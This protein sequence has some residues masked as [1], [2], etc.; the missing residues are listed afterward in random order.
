MD[1]Q[2]KNNNQGKFFVRTLKID[3]ENT[4]NEESRTMRFPIASDEPVS[5]GFVTEILSHEPGAMRLGSRQKSMPLLFNHDWN[6]LCGV[7]EAIDQQEHR[8]YATVRFA[9][10]EEGEKAFNLVRERILTNV[11]CGYQVNRARSDP[12]TRTRTATDW[13]LFEVSLVTVPADPT[14]GVYRSFNQPEFTEEKIMPDQENKVEARKAPEAVQKESK[15]DIAEIQKRAAAEAT[16]RIREIQGMCRDFHISES[17]ADEFINSDRSVDQVRAAVME[18]L[19]SRQA[20]PAALE[21]R[22]FELDMDIGLTE[23]EKSAYSLT[24]ALKAYCTGR[25]NQA[26]FEREVN[27]ALCKR[28]GRESQGFFMP[29]DIPFVGNRAYVA[30]SDVDGGHTIAT[31]LRAGSFIEMIRMKSIILQLGATYLTGLRGKVEIPRQTGSGSAQ[32]IPETG[33]VEPSNAKFDKIA[34]NMKTV[35]AK[36]F[37]SRNLMMQSSLNVESFVRAELVRILAEAID[38]AALY[39]AG[40]NYEPLGIANYDGIHV[41]EGGENGANL[42]FDHLIQMETMVAE[43]NA[44]VANM[45]Y[46]VNSRTIGWLKQLK[47]ENGQ[48]FWKPITS[49]V[50]NAMPGELNG[51]PVARSN[52]V[53]SNLTKG[54]AQEICSQVFFANWADMIIGEW[55]VLEVLPNPYSTTAYDNGGLEIRVL[56]SLDINIR[57]PESFCVMNDALVG[58]TAKKTP[59]PPVQGGDEEAGG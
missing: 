27:D 9:K 54:S 44:D 31:D 2:T 28:M 42:S 4:P 18:K 3:S 6:R 38:Q 48:Y 43:A 14:V 21:N 12:D 52:R 47:D 59:T 33:T 49:A 55:G 16:L 45:S 22:S 51:Y 26:G 32:W 24:R 37:V 36:S 34:L 58:A 57:H 8:T 50:R 15:I 53:K 7:V 1:E 10:S 29:T 40:Q 20:E 35:A 56:Q 13:E 5:M 41:V 46:L 39:G 25:W 17:E 30:G 19:K 23:Q 11:S